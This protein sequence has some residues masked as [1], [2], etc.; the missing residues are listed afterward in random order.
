M[1]LKAAYCQF[2]LKKEQTGAAC[3]TLHRRKLT[4]LSVRFIY[5]NTDEKQCA[6]NAADVVLINELHRGLWGCTFTLQWLIKWPKLLCMNNSCV[7][8]CG[9]ARLGRFLN[10]CRYLN[11][12]SFVVFELLLLW[13]KTPVSREEEGFV[14]VWIM[15]GAEVQSKWMD[16][17]HQILSFW[18]WDVAHFTCPADSSVFILLLFMFLQMQIQKMPLGHDIIFSNMSLL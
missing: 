9:F 6:L 12:Y 7:T 13:Y 11:C 17:I 16:C 8:H 3:Q 10:Y 1:A 2:W 15:L 4:Y 14:S 18:C 5:D